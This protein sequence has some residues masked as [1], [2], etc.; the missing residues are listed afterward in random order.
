MSGFSNPVLKLG[1]DEGADCLLGPTTRVTRGRV[2]EHKH[3]H[4][5]RLRM[6]LGD[7]IAR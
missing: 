2:E 5:L 6:L 1:I 3:R 7:V 4:E